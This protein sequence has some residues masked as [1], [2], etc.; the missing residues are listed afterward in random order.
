MSGKIV[1]MPKVKR[2]FAVADFK[3]H[4]PGSIQVR[5]RHWVKGL[6]RLGH[7]V[8][9]FSYRNIVSQYSPYGSLRWL[10]RKKAN[11]LL[12]EQVK[13]Y[14]P[15]IILLLAMKYLDDKMVLAMRQV[16]PNAVIVGMEVDWFTQSKSDRIAVA[17]Q[18]DI[19]IS[20]RSGEWLKTYKDAG[21]P[22]C[23]FI[24]NPCD[25]DLQ[26][27][28]EVDGKW[29]SDIVF[30]GKAEH[31]SLPRNNDRYNLLLRLSQMHSTKLYG[32]FDNPPVYGV[33]YFFAISGARIALSI[34][35]VNNVR[36][37][38]SDRLIN[39]IGCGT[40]TLAKYVPD[41][42]LLFKDAVHVKYFD[43]V[44]EF[45][46]LADWYLRHEQEREKIAKAG[47]QR[48]HSEFNCEKVAQ[49]LMD[50]IEKGY[51]NAP[52]AEIL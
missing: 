27:P 15:D 32:C 41:S 21:V 36:L 38:Y 17:R 45:F 28:Y 12:Y 43:T 2:I 33:D 40:F 49:Y 10:G 26:H 37:Y 20:T 7:D 18:T 24:P 39:Y 35:I 51:Y 48:A 13:N 42:D 34:N 16:S 52:Y 8:Q 9:R 30:T 14:R 47:M 29:K 44:D 31:L 50:L 6:I 23:A 22:S 1:Q 11:M 25:P 46:E 4:L 19:V 5:C 3:D